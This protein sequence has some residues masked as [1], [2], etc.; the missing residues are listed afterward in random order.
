MLTDGVEAHMAI[1]D[2]TMGHLEHVVLPDVITSDGRTLDG[3][4]HETP[5]LRSHA[6]ECESARRTTT[7]C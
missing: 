3:R 6:P 5:F 1:V 2:T 7:R 4:V